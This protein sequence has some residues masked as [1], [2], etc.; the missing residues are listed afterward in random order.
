EELA[1]LEAR[2]SK[3]RA[4][5][6]GMMQS[7]PHR[8]H[9]PRMNTSPTASA[10]EHIR[11]FIEARGT[12]WVRLREGEIIRNQQERHHFSP[13]RAITIKETDHSRL[14]GDLLNPYGSHGEDPLFLHSFLA[15]IGMD[16]PESGKWRV[17]V[18]QGRVD[19]IFRQPLGRDDALTDR[20]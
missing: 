12:D 20:A 17:T 18:E 13:L 3:I 10:H 8:P 4:L 1:A 9:P 15:R 11:S 7:P 14:L 19:I 5:K 2:L 16:Q 6:Q